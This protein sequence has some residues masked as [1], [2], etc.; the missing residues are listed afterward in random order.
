ML[1]D[2]LSGFA[3][4][5]SAEHSN[6]VGEDISISTFINAIIP[7][8]KLIIFVLFYCGFAS[9][10][11]GGDDCCSKGSGF[12]FFDDL[13]VGS[14]MAP[15]CTKVRKKCGRGTVLIIFAGLTG[16]G[17]AIGTIETL[18][19]TAKKFTEG[20]V[21]ASA[22]PANLIRRYHLEPVGWLPRF[23][24]LGPCVARIMSPPN[25]GL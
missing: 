19:E 24:E 12:E 3:I 20:W 22:A 18:V 16:V 7:I 14:Y 21:G 17:A 11:G 1:E 15:T 23:Y 8:G 13:E 5:D 10:R 4:W 6:N 9:G 2:L 25:P